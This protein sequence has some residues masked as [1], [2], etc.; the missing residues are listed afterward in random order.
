MNNKTLGRTVLLSII[1][2]GMALAPALRA[3]HSTEYLDAYQAA[4]N[5]R[6][7]NFEGSA[8]EE[9]ALNAAAR[10]LN[11]NTTTPATDLTKLASAATTLD[12]AFPEDE[13]FLIRGDE[14]IDSYTALAESQLAA[15]NAR[16]GENEV[17]TSLTRSLERIQASLDTAN[18]ENNTIPV[19]ARAA[20]KAFKTLQLATR[21][22]D[23]IFKAPATLDGVD[24][25]LTGR[26]GFGV[27]LNAGNFYTIPGDPEE[28]GTWSYEPTGLKTG[29]IIATPNDG[30]GAVHTLNL[31]FA[32]PTRGTFT[33]TTAAGEEVSGRFTVTAVD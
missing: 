17:P 23:R 29:T 14:A 33:G 30:G 18:D 4:V 2:I 8:Q 9:R 16:I 25:T 5:D 21:A 15:L 13:E 31:T 7:A 12:R 28:N 10:T 26:G 6:L 3:A 32:T 24:V 11:R 22:V 20:S 19:R 1:C 27:T